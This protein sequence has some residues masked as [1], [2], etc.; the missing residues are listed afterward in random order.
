LEPVK[1]D[2]EPDPL[3]TKILS[4]LRTLEQTFRMR[5]RSIGYRSENG[6][7]CIYKG[8]GPAVEG[9]QPST[10][11]IVEA[12]YNVKG[13]IETRIDGPFE[14][15]DDAYWLEVAEHDKTRVA[16]VTPE[17][18]HFVVVS[19]SAQPNGGMGGAEYRIVITN[20]S[21]AEYMQAANLQ[22]EDCSYDGEDWYLLT[23][24]NLWGQG[25]IPPKHRH[26]FQVNC[27]VL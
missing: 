6:M 11:W 7:L 14:D 13:T 5:S 25:V 19:D 26:L 8:Y 10:V 20:D 4:E 3:W 21:D 23:T 18:Q 27:K 22:I 2:Y 15:N 16:L 12:Y 1:L 17:Y 24:H 9:Y